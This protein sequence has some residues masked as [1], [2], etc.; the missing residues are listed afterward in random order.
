MVTSF[1]STNAFIVCAFQQTNSKQNTNF[2]NRRFICTPK[3]FVNHSEIIQIR[4]V[5]DRDIYK[6]SQFPV[7]MQAVEYVN[8]FLSKSSSQ[9]SMKLWIYLFLHFDALV[10]N[11]VSISCSGSVK[12]LSGYLC[13]QFRS[14][15]LWW[16]KCNFNLVFIDDIS[17]HTVA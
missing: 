13:R 11:F 4:V 1:D 5:L 10:G 14:T 17:S 7:N 6:I 12:K 16:W 9:D 3:I 15:Y 8:V 2:A